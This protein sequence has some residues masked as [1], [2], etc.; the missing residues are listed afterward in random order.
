MNPS[1]LKPQIDD[2]NFD[3]Y[4]EFNIM[5]NQE[6]KYRN[7]LKKEEFNKNSNKSFSINTRKNFI[8]PKNRTYLDKVK[9]VQKYVRFCLSIKKFNER[10]D[11][12]TNILE[13]DSTVNVIKDKN[14]EKNLLM[15][16]KGEQLS[17]Q[18]INSRKLTSYTHTIF[19]RMNINKYKLNRY[20]LKTPLTYID[21]Y[22][23]N[24]LYI[25]TWTLEKIFHG[26]G[27]FYTSNNKYEG[28]WN[29]GK[30]S[31]EGR[32]FY[33]N[34]DYY[35]GGFVDGRSNGFGKYFHS[36][37]TIYEGNWLNDQP[38]GNGKETFNDGSKFDGIFENGF[39]KKGKFTW[40][41]GSFYDGE[42]KNNYFEGYGRFKWKEGREYIGFWKNGKMSGKGVMN[43]TDGAKYEGEFFEGKRHGKGNYFW[44]KNKYYKGN[45][46]KGKQEGDGYYYN[47]G[48]GI[49]GIWSDG[50]MKKCLS[51]EI[52]H[53]LLCSKINEER[54]CS[55][56]EKYCKT[57]TGKSEYYYDSINMSTN[58]SNNSMK[59]VRYNINSNKKNEKN[60]TEIKKKYQS[61]KVIYN[62][63]SLTDFSIISDYSS[64]R[65]KITNIDVLFQKN[66][67]SSRSKKSI[68]SKNL[69]NTTWNN[70]TYYKKYKK[71]K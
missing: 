16:N 57:M 52:N 44:N 35:I 64:N 7:N 63:K 21:K 54:P 46:S 28:F 4:S 1:C 68:I 39:K 9:I 53:E 2:N 31:G 70:G 32:K 5:K 26:Y 13:L 18:L 33:Q 8:N 36:D 40:V 12:L 34:K 14:L 62:K 6:R 25:G 38:N 51:Q 30:L 42:I 66:C 58:L 17:L 27:I 67:N 20:L 59:D 47:K 3:N 71:K 10:I 65:S 69:E 24:D 55:P 56:S 45:W 22:K 23:N 37:G 11:L 61:S 49:I 48:K 19:Y 41:D 60:K 15:N 29:L 43:Y 50:K